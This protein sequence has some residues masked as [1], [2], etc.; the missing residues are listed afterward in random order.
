MLKLKWLRVQA[1]HDL[2]PEEYDLVVDYTARYLGDISNF[3][4][5]EIEA[6][7]KLYMKVRSTSL[8]APSGRGD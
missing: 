5:E 7:D 1:I 2:S 6:L 3:S 4:K 8:S